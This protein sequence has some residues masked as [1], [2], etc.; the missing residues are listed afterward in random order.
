[1]TKKKFNRLRYNRGY[2]CGA[3]DA[4]NDNGVGWRQNLQNELE[5]LEIIWLDPTRKPIERCP[6]DMETKQYLQTSKRL[7][8]Y[9]AV[10]NT[11]RLIRS[12]DLRMTDIS[13]FLV[14]NIDLKVFSCGTW[15]ELFNANREKKPIILRVE[16]GKEMCP[17]WIYGVLPHEMIFSTWAEVHAYLRHVAYD[18]IIETF[19]RWN[20][21][22][23]SINKNLPGVK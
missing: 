14:V 10:A 9:E 6:E 20:F 8:N 12:I 15:E 11:M 22:D 5:D 23:F 17:N 16:Q 4:A 7:H 21:F 2:L 19:K 1:M 3:M 13:D 18:P